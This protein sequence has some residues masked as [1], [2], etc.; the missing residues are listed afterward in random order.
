MLDSHLAEFYAVE[1]KQI[2]RAVKR[3]TEG[4]P[5]TFM[6]QLSEN[7][8][9]DLRFQNDTL[10]NNSALRFQNGTLKDGRGQHHKYLP[11]VFLRCREHPASLNN[12]PINIFFIQ[13]GLK[14]S[15]SSPV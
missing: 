1:T 13:K 7:E 8:W 14:M 5:N 2:N 10:E 3:N 15:I 9:K 11:F 12:I 6:F 4:F